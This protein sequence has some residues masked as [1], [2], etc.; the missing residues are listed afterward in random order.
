[1]KKTIIQFLIFLSYLSFSIY[2]NAQSYTFS[3]TSGAYSDL[4]GST[5]LN[6]TVIWDN[7]VYNI[8]IG[9]NFDYFDQLFNSLNVGDGWIMFDSLNNFIIDV[10][11]ANLTD[12]NIIVSQNVPEI[13]LVTFDNATVKNLIVWEKTITGAASYIIYKESGVSGIYDSVGNVLNDSLSIFIDITSN[14]F[15][16][17]DRY[18]ISTIYQ[19]GNVSAKSIAH[20]TIHL[21]LNY[22]IPPPSVN[23]IW[24]NYEGFSYNYVRIWRG[25]SPSNLI[26]I[27]SI[28]SFV[29]TYTDLAPPPS[30][31]LYYQI[32]VTNPTGC[33][34]ALSKVLSYNSAKSNIA[35]IDNI[36]LKSLNNPFDQIIVQK[37][38]RQNSVTEIQNTLSASPISYQ[39]SGTPGSQI[40]KIEWKNAGFFN[41]YD[42]VCTADD[43]VNVQLWLFEGTNDIEI[44]IG[45]NSISSVSFGGA[46]G[47]AVGLKNNV[48]PEFIYL[49]GDPNNPVI[50]NSANSTTN[51][52]PANGTI[53]KFTRNPS[54]ISENSNLY[55]IS[56]FPNPVREYLII[57][58]DNE[59]LFFAIF[60]LSGRM[61]LK[62]QYSYIDKKI[63]LSFLDEGFYYLRINNGNTITYTKIIKQ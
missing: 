1:M 6:D 61:V 35:S 43:S 53:Y 58:K 56:V 62:N 32:E 41:E 50:V 45:A 36:A 40:L 14:P 25:A 24:D 12:R 55:D 60:D 18:K 47:P 34:A 7:P 37:S 20:K 4:T 39:L 19:C 46:T 22:G 44:H 54:G 33:T 16:K 38:T 31:S 10:F 9:F 11:S 5:S 57:N 8:P 51:G 15:I 27:D 42:S 28:S 26:L 52:S 59:E 3:K 13:C 29:S 30:D 2:C 17:S 49:S 23:L 63:D 48:S 21:V